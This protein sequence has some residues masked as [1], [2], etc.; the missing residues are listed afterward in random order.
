[1]ALSGR[2]VLCPTTFVRQWLEGHTKAKVL[3]NPDAAH[4]AGLLKSPAWQC[5]ILQHLMQLLQSTTSSDAVAAQPPAAAEGAESV[6]VPAAAAAGVEVIPGSAAVAAEAGAAADATMLV[7]DSSSVGSEAGWQ[8]STVAAASPPAAAHT[9]A[10]AAAAGVKHRHAASED[11]DDDNDD[12]DSFDASFMALPINGLDEAVDLDALID[13]ASDMVA[14]LVEVLRSSKNSLRQQGKDVWDGLV[15]GVALPGLPGLPNLPNLT[16]LP[17]LSNLPNLPGLPVQLQPLQWQQSCS[18][19]A[20]REAGG[21]DQAPFGQ[22]LK[23]AWVG[24]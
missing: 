16:N 5:T 12:A 19:D 6:A 8:G 22:W 7:D 18:A 3:F 4:G 11:D 14:C 10:A 23:S 2:D 24:G 17:N 1:M 15:Q 21:Y 20:A 13:A 9:A